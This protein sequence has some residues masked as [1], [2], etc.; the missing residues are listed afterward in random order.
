MH[1]GLPTSD[2]LSFTDCCSP[3][4]VLQKFASYFDDVGKVSKTFIDGKENVNLINVKYLELF[5]KLYHTVQT[6]LMISLKCGNIFSSKCQRPSNANVVVSAS[7]YDTNIAAQMNENRQKRE[8][9]VAKLL[10][11]LDVTAIKS[12]H[13][14]FIA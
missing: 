4:Y 6:T 11:M 8:E 10:T 5:G 2:G 14:E 9:E 7:Q 13:A 3:Q 12:A 1:E